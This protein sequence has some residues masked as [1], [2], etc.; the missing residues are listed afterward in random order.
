[1]EH[2]AGFFLLSVSFEN[3]K[4]ERSCLKH[5]RGLIGMKGQRIQAKK[6]EPVTR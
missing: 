2:A 3:I 1:M 6:D 5:M 4:T